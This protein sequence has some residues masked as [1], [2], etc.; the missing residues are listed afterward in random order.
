VGRWP[1]EVSRR[2]YLGPMSLV[3]IYTKKDC[4]YSRGAKAL[5]GRMG[6]DYEDIDVTHDKRRL[7]EMME[8]ANG[9]ISV[10]QIFIAGHHIGGLS[11]LTRLQQR[12]DLASM[13]GNQDSMPSPS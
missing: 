3:T 1:C 10:P 11:E 12:G 5:L 2:A 9:G 4:P 13:V 6:I 7:L 8:R